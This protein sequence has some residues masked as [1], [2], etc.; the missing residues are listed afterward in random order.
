MSSYPELPSSQP[1]WLDDLECSPNDTNLRL[2]PHS[3]TG[4]SDC[5]HSDDIILSCVASE[6]I[7]TL[8]MQCML[9]IEILSSDIASNTAS[10]LIAM[11]CGSHR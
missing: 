4:L 9:L 11:I 6:L 1:I 3:G 5:Q 10:E 2:C 7:A 8:S